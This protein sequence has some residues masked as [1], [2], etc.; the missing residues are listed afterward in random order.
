MKRE[1][2]FQPRVVTTS[3][4]DLTEIFCFFQKRVY[5]IG[6]KQTKG[7]RRRLQRA[8]FNRGFEKMFPD[9]SFYACDVSHRAILEAVNQFR[10]PLCCRRCN[11]VAFYVRNI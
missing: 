8:G 10:Y 7:F 6:K 3:M 1:S 2:N 4:F 5:Q 9:F 11:Q